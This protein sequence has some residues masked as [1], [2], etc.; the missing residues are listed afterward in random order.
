[1]TV[2]MSNGGVIRRAVSRGLMPALIFAL[3]GTSVSAM[4]DP[5]L[6]WSHKEWSAGYEM[7]R[8]AIWTGGDGSGI[9]EIE[10]DMGG[11]N[12]SASYLP[13]VYSNYPIPLRE[14]DEFELYIDHQMSDFGPEMGFYDSM[15]S[16]GRYMVAAGMTDGFVPDLIGTFRGA[17]SVAV[18]VLHYGEPPFVAD[19]FSLSG[20]TATYLKISEWCRFDPNHLFRS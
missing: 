16:Y 7:G 8:C 12:A 2:H 11:Y 10:V 1:M 17:N 14:D 6:V 13:I 9:F 20:F 19:E 4:D 5:E 18:E 15:D 3:G